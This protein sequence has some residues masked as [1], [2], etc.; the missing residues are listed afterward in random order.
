VNSNILIY[1]RFSFFW[2][3]LAL[4]IA[5]IDDVQQ[6]LDALAEAA[7]EHYDQKQISIQLHTFSSPED[8]W[9]SY[10]LFT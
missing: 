1:C 4:N 10:L 9:N 7:R 2:R 6:D 3:I 8:F 5:I